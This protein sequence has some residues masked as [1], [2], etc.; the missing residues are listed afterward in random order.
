MSI[1]ELGYCN[2][3]V[4]QTLRIMVKKNSKQNIL[5][6]VIWTGQVFLAINFIILGSLKLT[7]PFNELAPEMSFVLVIPQALTRFIGVAEVLGGLG[8]ILPSILRIKPILTSLSALGIATIMLFAIAYHIY[9]GEYIMIGFN[10][11]IGLVALIIAWARF[12]KLPI[13]GS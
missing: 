11:I 13:K 10:L 7:L 5:N 3:L 8:L 4:K 2:Q 6:I 1:E 12:K 9:Q